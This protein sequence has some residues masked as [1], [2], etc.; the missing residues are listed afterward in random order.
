MEESGEP[1]MST[2]SSR[3]AKRAERAAGPTPA[4]WLGWYS[5]AG[6]IDGGAGS[7]SEVT[8]HSRRLGRIAGGFVTI[9]GVTVLLGLLFGSGLGFGGSEWSNDSPSWSPDG[10]HIV[11][12]RD[13]CPGGGF[14][15]PDYDDIL[16]VRRDGTGA[17]PAEANLRTSVTRLNTCLVAGREADCLR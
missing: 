1:T 12:V 5:G 11:F 13:H 16:I 9:A 4:L 8:T 2:K 14:F 6:S 7:A 10:R 17:A 3:S 15:C